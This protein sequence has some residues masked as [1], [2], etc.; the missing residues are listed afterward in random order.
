MEIKERSV[1][2]SK[3]DSLDLYRWYALRE[4]KKNEE[5]KLKKPELSKN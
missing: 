3:V 4:M 5:Y 2:L 1:I